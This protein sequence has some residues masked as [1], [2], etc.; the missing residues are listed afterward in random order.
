MV[1]RRQ[2][3]PASGGLLPHAFC[4]GFGG[5]LPGSLRAPKEPTPYRPLKCQGQGGCHPDAPFQ[6]HLDQPGIPKACCALEPHWGVVSLSPGPDQERG[7][8]T[9]LLKPTSRTE[10]GPAHC[11]PPQSAR[12]RRKPSQ[13]PSGT[14]LRWEFGEVQPLPSQA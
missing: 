13:L 3:W 9:E 12:P 14:A 7:L 4:G 8:D 6:G 11:S 10:H 5:G 1:H 2:L